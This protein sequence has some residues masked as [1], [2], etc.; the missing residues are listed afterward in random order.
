MLSLMP[1]SAA[2]VPCK[3]CGE[4]APIYGTVDFNRNCQIEG[5]IKLPLS[6]TPVRYRRCPACGFLFTDAF[7]CWSQEQFKTHIYNEGYAVVDPE[8]AESRPRN[9]AAAVVALFG[10]HRSERRVLDYGGGNDALCTHLRAAGF[11]VAVTYDPFAPDFATPPPPDR[12]LRRQH[13]PGLP[14]AAGFRAASGEVGHVTHGP[15]TRSCA[16]LTRASM[17]R[18]SK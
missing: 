14:H 16:G 5:G 4:P 6:G 11:P 13:A 17:M 8:Y 2:L 7:D 12:L 1:V 3:I 9:N 15:S 18:L 10:A